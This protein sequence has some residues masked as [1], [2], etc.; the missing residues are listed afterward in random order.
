MCTIILTFYLNIQRKESLIDVTT[1]GTGRESLPKQSTLSL[2]CIEAIDRMLE[3]ESTPIVLRRAFLQSE[4]VRKELL[5]W[6][7]YRDVLCD[8][9]RLY[10]SRI[11]RDSAPTPNDTMQVPHMKVTRSLWSN[12]VPTPTRTVRLNMTTNSISHSCYPLGEYSVILE[13]VGREIFHFIAR[14]RFVYWDF[15]KSL[16]NLYH[17]GASK[18]VTKAEC[19]LY[20]QLHYVGGC[21]GDQG[22]RDGEYFRG[23]LTVVVN[24]SGREEYNCHVDPK[25]MRVVALHVDSNLEVFHVPVNDN[26]AFIHLGSEYEE[27]KPYDFVLKVISGKLPRDIIKISSNPEMVPSSTNSS[28]TWYP[29]KNVKRLIKGTSSLIVDASTT[30]AKTVIS[31]VASDSV[32]SKIVVNFPSIMNFVSQ[33]LDGRNPYWNMNCCHRASLTDLKPC[34][35]YRNHDEYQEE[36]IGFHAHLLSETTDSTVLV[37][38]SQ[39]FRYSEFFPEKSIESLSDESS[40]SEGGI[41]AA[42]E[43][44]YTLNSDIS[45]VVKIVRGEDL[46]SPDSRHLSMQNILTSTTDTILSG[47][48]VVNSVVSHSNGL[49]KSVSRKY[50]KDISTNRSPRVKVSFATFEKQVPALYNSF[51]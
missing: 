42:V 31:T 44:S 46:L 24:G 5:H 51:R 40:I 15:V 8:I 11:C 13:T 38:G 43:K 20:R 10:S 4:I 16:R 6:P 12:K 25:T 26:I 19:V 2:K 9:N 34:A 18:R 17:R 33:A 49:E 36:V 3:N 30:V 22:T 35:D 21:D 45:L 47:V 37:L 32:K 14:N 27:Y 1:A 39:F 48:D 28:D 7:Y 41:S 29:G 50:T 23:K